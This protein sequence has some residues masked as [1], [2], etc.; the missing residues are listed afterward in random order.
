MLATNM[1]R[2]QKVIQDVEAYI[3]QHGGRYR[4]WYAGIATKPRDRLF[5]DHNI[6]EKTDAWIFRDCG[7]E[8]TAR[9][10]EK[11]FLGKGCDGGTGG[12]ITPTFFYAYKKKAHTNP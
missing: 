12:G 2:Y 6:N 8:S 5:N 3:G 9:K 4:E 11:H 1:T 10:V 7:S